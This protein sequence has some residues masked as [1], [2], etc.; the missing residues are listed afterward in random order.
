MYSLLQG[1][2]LNQTNTQ[3]TKR[4]MSKRTK[5]TGLAAPAPEKGLAPLREGFATGITPTPKVEAENAKQE[6]ILQAHQKR[7]NSALK[8]YAEKE[9]ELRAAATAYIDM[10]AKASAEGNKLV[11]LSNGGVGYVTSKG[12]YKHIQNPTDL[13][14]IRGTNG[15]PTEIK[16]LAG[17]PEN[18][19]SPGELLD[20]VPKLFVGD[21]MIQGQSCGPVGT[22]VQVM[23]AS[24]PTTNTPSWD[25]C[26]KGVLNNFELLKGYETND[27][28]T[29][30]KN[31]ATASADMGRSGFLLQQG[32]NNIHCY[33]A[34]SGFDIANV[35]GSIATKSVKSDTIWSVSIDTNNVAGGLLY[36]GQ[37]AIGTLGEND[38]LPSSTN[39][40]AWDIEGIDNCDPVYAPSI[41]V[42]DATWGNNCDGVR[43]KHKH[44]HKYY[45]VS[46]NNVLENVKSNAN[47][48]LVY[49]YNVGLSTSDPAKSC[50]KEFTSS[51]SCY[52]DGSNSKTLFVEAEAKGKATFYRCEKE[53]KECTHSKLTITDDGNV[54]LFDHAGSTIWQSGTSKTGL[55]VAS[56]NAK[57]SKYGRNYIT[58]DEYLKIGEF[59]GSPSGNC[60]YTLEADSDG[61]VSLLIKYEVLGCSSDNDN[62]ATLGKSG[63]IGDKNNSSFAV[64]KMKDGIITTE[65]AGK[66][67]YIDENMVRRPIPSKYVSNGN[68]YFSIGN[69]DAP[70]ND[71]K[72]ET[73]ISDATA[74]KSLCNS[75]EDCHG[76][77]FDP[78]NLT[79]YLKNSNTFPLSGRIPSDN[80][81]LYI[82]KQAVSVNSSFPTSVTQTYGDV[83]YNLPVGKPV[84]EDTVTGIG[85]ILAK[86]QAA[87]DA[88]E[89]KLQE[90][91]SEIRAEMNTLAGQEGKLNEDML[92]Q[93]DQLLRDMAKYEDNKKQLK[94]A[95]NRITNVTA[96]N[97]SSQ[98]DMISESYHYMLLVIAACI[99]VI[100]GIKASR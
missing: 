42:Q 69:Y 95:N 74:C 12:T 57:N 2:Q 91:V 100:G 94:A 48:K 7:F 59:V 98:L 11:K 72:R 81:E 71:I 15:C 40:K 24:N 93:I 38:N 50:G 14:S 51:Y 44:K 43:K 16:A 31:C 73:S 92:S 19:N 82:R 32:N 78:T 77:V 54:T 87:A 52:H 22:N 34:K 85:M 99:L 46:N 60:Y 29:A 37:I 30:I 25:G 90:V 10:Q 66:L 18:F 80:L 67:S 45:S 3:K 47:G 26:R 56:K 76:V 86:K 61:L 5:N 89:K 49:K 68:N 58:S 17:N 35:G 70:G 9:E 97:E 23:G 39:Y 27:P 62:N 4:I 33:T 41:T 1:S 96:M 79:C 88:A 20:T 63:M 21:S 84:S 36:N 75:L 53:N 83:F 64:Y 55:S 28:T 8:N 6:V 13:E 65:E